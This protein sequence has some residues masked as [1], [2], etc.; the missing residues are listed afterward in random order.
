MANCQTLGG[1][2]KLDTLFSLDLDRL[3]QNTPGQKVYSWK[4]SLQQALNRSE[5]FNSK[6]ETKRFVN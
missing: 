6:F 4:I 3:S 5:G 2:T 1:Y